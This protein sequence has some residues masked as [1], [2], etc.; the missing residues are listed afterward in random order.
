MCF[1]L[2]PG[3]EDGMLPIQ[4]LNSFQ[5]LGAI[6]GGLLTDLSPFASPK[7]PQFLIFWQF[8]QFLFQ[9][10]TVGDTSCYFVTLSLPPLY[11]SFLLRD[12]HKHGLVRETTLGEVLS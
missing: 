4:Q 12:K 8:V 6:W 1:P 11:N 9:F 3:R 2:Q 10:L 7:P 5:G